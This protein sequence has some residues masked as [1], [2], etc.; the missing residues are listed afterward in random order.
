MVTNAV[1]HNELL[2]GNGS[3]T[4]YAGRPAGDVL[5]GDYKP[6]TQSTSQVDRLSGGPGNDFIYASHGTNYIYTGGGTDAVHAHFGRG[7]IHC[8]SAG[9]TVFL[10]HASRPRYR[11]F[12]CEHIS[13]STDGY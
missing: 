4:I 3:D 10:S 8:D 13:Y 1:L 9:V 7:E 5:W 11:L 2:G 6:G 12:G